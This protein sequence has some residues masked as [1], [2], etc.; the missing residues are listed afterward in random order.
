MEYLENIVKEFEKVKNDDVLS[1]DK[2]SIEYA[3]LMTNLE[4]EYNISIANIEEFE[5]LSKDI[6]ELYLTI[7]NERNI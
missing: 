1:R 6:K 3:K 7:A 2:K 5:R 4:T